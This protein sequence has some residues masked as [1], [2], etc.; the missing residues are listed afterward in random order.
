MDAMQQRVNVTLQKFSMSERAAQE[1]DQLVEKYG[2]E[3][4]RKAER[5]KDLP[6]QKK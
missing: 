6:G 3:A 5:L 4:Y 2:V 1:L